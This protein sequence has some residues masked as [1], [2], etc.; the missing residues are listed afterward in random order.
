MKRTTFSGRG[1]WRKPACT[2]CTG[3]SATRSTRR[4][5]WWCGARDI[6]FAATCIWHRQLQSQHR[7][8]LHRYRPAHLPPGFRRGCH[9]LFQSAHRHLPVQPMRKLLVAPFELHTR[10]FEVD[11]ARNRNAGKGSAGAHHRQSEFAG[12]VKESLRR[13]YRASQAGVKN[14][15][16]RARHLLLAPGVKGFSENITVRSIVDRFLEHSRIYYFENACQ[17][18]VFVGSA[19]WMPR[20]F[21]RASSCVPH[22]G[23]RFARASH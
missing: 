8:A 13:L 3:W 18:Q 1:D 9:E 11:R 14:R 21:F 5:A 15:S 20:N 10:M 4:A 6:T 23:R 16:D 7:A 2:S 17:P 22:R 19:D 12:R